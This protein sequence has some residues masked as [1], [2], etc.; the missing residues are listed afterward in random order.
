MKGLN[1]YHEAAKEI[2]N[3]WCLQPGIAEKVLHKLDSKP[4]VAY[5]KAVHMD[6]AD[7]IVLCLYQKDR[8]GER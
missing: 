8:E 7:F 5:E 3:R 2:G 4:E 1:S 6:V